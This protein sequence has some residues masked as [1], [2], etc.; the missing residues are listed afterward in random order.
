MENLIR[1]LSLSNGL[2]VSF[3]SRTRRYFGDYHLVKLEITCKIAVCAD[4]FVNR[5]E[6]DAAL[7]LLGEVVVYRRN[8]EQMG[9]PS[10]EIAAVQNRLVADFEQHSLSY[11][12]APSFP[13]KLVAAELNKI[14]KKGRHV[15]KS[16]FNS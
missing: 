8:L 15:Q 7:L 16:S 5:E 12:S 1:E 9:V 6:F 4:Y 13:R 14:I 3:V 10:S 11:F 2:S